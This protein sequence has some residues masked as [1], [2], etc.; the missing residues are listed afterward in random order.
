MATERIQIHGLHAV[1]AALRRDPLAVEHVWALE[2]REDA[3]MREVLEDARAAGAHV[4]R[5]GRAALDRLVQ[6]A[7]H[8]GVVARLRP[9]P[10]GDERTL[11]VLLEALDEPALLLVLDGVQDPHNLGACLRTAD[12]VGVHAVLVPRDRACGLTPTVRKV[13]SGAA[14]SVAFIQ[15]T[16]LARSLRALQQS[17]VWLVGAAGEAAQE[18]Y[19]ADLRGPLALVLGAEGRGLRRLT[20]EVCDV[21]VRLPMHGAVSSLNVSVAAGACLYEA[22]RQRR[23]S[24]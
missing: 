9:R 8:Q 13:A 5:I 11:E 6:G 16:N 20:R 12:A 22:L 15:V 18:L 24:A 19:E 2:G 7:S 17:G 23:P 14:E 10:A 3:R 21:L 4:E 1:A